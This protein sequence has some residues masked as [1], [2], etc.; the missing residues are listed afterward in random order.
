M[1]AVLL[2]KSSNNNVK[3]K[4]SKDKE[5][6]KII[7]VFREISKRDGKIKAENGLIKGVWISNAP[8]I[9]RITFDNSYSMLRPKTINYSIKL[10]ERNQQNNN[11]NT[12]KNNKEEEMKYDE[13]NKEMKINNTQ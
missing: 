9:L 8:G 4:K 1:S 7:Q 3:E 13:S 12:S 10:N 6:E 2:N 11:I 5:D